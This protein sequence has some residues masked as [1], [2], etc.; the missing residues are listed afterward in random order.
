MQQLALDI[1]QPRPMPAWTPAP[2][3][4]ARSSDPSTS[5]GAAD[6][7]KQLAARHHLTIL[8]A[9]REH[10]PASKDRIAALTCLTGTQVARRTVE[11]QRDGLIRATGRTVASTAGRQERAW[12]VA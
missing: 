5:H 12:A 1:E 10:G 6:Q 8:R 7:A 11:L 9:L 2:V 4:L 3:P